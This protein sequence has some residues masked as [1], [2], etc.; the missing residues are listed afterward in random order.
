MLRSGT[1]RLARL[2]LVP[3]VLAPHALAAQ[4][5]PLVSRL[6]L[7]S[8]RQIEVLM[9]S[10]A[11]LGLPPEALWSKTL[12]GIAKGIPNGRIVS[13]VRRHFAALREARNALGTNISLDE[14]AAA[15]GAL[16][17]G[18]P[19]ESLK[20]LRTARQ[21]KSILMPLV[22]LSDLVS[23][24]VPPEDASTAIV[25]MSQRGALDSDFAGLRRGV[26]TDILS[27]AP[28]AAAL[29]R[30]TREFPGRGAPAGTRLP[31]SA[32]QRPQETPGTNR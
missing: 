15:A 7:Q 1:R 24:G 12:E 23:R 3:L 32:P 27:G 29:D 4:Q 8:R 31:S 21:D 18:V 19:R 16:T 10:A 2:L 6:D 28:P 20:S 11:G 26:E 5:S 30:R 22:V 14:L 25:A 13:G 9:D 17:A